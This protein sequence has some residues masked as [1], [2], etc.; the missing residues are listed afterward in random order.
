MGRP[1]ATGSPATGRLGIVGVHAGEPMAAGGRRA[2]SRRL[3]HAKTKLQTTPAPP[4]VLI[5][6][7]LQQG[8]RRLRAARPTAA[9]GSSTWTP[10]SPGRVVARAHSCRPPPLLQNFFAMVRPVAGEP[11]AAGRPIAKKN[12]NNGG[13]VAKFF[14]SG[15]P[16]AAGS[17]AT[18]HPDVKRH[19]FSLPTEELHRQSLPPSTNLPPRA[20]LWSVLGALPI[21][22]L[23][24]FYS[25]KAPIKDQKQ[26]QKQQ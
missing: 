8:G 25:Q 21:L 13:G 11:A 7:I 16:A 22:D 14:T 4:Q 26:H 3:P 6:K 18:G 24:H 5:E 1:A 10:T 15:R 2:R 19:R 9:L 12:C 23:P 17:P 20:A